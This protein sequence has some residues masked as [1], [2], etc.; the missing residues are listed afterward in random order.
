MAYCVQ[1]Q[2]FFFLRVVVCLLFVCCFWQIYNTNTTTHRRP[3]KETGTTI[4]RDRFTVVV[5]MIMGRLGSLVVPFVTI[6]NVRHH[7]PS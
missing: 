5:L 3:Q 2:T 1:E 7:S 6:V 4:G